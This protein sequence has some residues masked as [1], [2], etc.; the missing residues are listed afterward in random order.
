M[1]VFVFFFFFWFYII[2]T[3]IHKHNA[4]THFGLIIFVLLHD[5]PLRVHEYDYNILCWTVGRRRSARAVRLAGTGRRDRVLTICRPS[6][7]WNAQPYMHVAVFF[8]AGFIWVYVLL[9][10]WQFCQQ[11]CGAARR[12]GMRGERIARGSFF[13]LSHGLLILAETHNNNNNNI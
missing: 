13:Y 4:L 1:F 9:S 5:P 2:I 7:N 3:N 6:S 10:C 12:Y 11:T 8:Y